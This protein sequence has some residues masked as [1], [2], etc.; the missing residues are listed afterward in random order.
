MWMVSSTGMFNDIFQFA[1]EIQ[2]MP[3]NDGDI[4]VSYDVTALFTNIPVDQ[5]IHILANKAFTNDWFNKTHGLQLKKEQL[6][7]LLEVAVKDQLF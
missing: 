4:L 1:D 3:I 6:I 7:E 2:Q 5:P